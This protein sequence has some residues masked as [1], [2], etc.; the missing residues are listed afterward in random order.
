MPSIDQ[1][2]EKIKAK[3]LET[4]QLVL[5]NHCNKVLLVNKKFYFI[6]V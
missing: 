2:S 6:K 3:I 1:W 4:T 5:Y